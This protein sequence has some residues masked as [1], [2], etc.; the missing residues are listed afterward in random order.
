M[1]RKPLQRKRTKKS[2]DDQ[3]ITTLEGTYHIIK[4]DADRILL[5]ENDFSLEEADSVKASIAMFL[6]LC[7]KWARDSKIVEKER[8]R[9]KELHRVMA[10]LL[11]D[12]YLK[13]MERSPVSLPIEVEPHEA[14]PRT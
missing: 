3:L 8:K 1:L 4:R 11:F 13:T 14:L 7:Y 9:I 6:L 10:Q 12:I 5:A 2:V